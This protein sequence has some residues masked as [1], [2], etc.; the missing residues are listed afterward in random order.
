MKLYKTIRNNGGWDNWNMEI[1]NFFNCK[2]NYEARKKEQEYFILLNATLNS[3]EPLPYP[4]IA[5]NAESL[6]NKKKNVKNLFY[7]KKCNISCST[8]KLLKVHNSTK[9]HISSFRT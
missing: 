9:K 7:C 3:V 4:R 8:E 5:Q 6:M 2:D 1:V